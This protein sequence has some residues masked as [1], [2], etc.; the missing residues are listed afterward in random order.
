[1]TKEE[2]LIDAIG[3]TKDRNVLIA[4][5]HDSADPNYK[6]DVHHVEFKEAPKL[7]EADI[8]RFRIRNGILGG[9]AAAVAITGGVVLWNNLR[10]NATEPK[11]AVTSA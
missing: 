7:S 5:G 9:L 6:T 1:M 8:K 11:P 10:D 4:V 3:D 2:K